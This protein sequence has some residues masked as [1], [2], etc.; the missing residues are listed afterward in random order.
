[1]EDKKFNVEVDKQERTPYI[2]PEKN[3]YTLY[4]ESISTKY[5]RN[6]EFALR[7]PILDPN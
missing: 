5:A 7:L 1:M 3:S 2:R 4:F 6:Q